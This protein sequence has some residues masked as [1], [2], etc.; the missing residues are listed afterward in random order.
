MRESGIDP[1]P[2]IAEYTLVYD[3]KKEQLKHHKH[4]H[5]KAKAS[6]GPCLCY[7]CQFGRQDPFQWSGSSGSAPGLRFRVSVSVRFSVFWFGFRVSGF[8]FRV[9]DFLVSIFVLCF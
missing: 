1:E 3:D 7:M 6:I 5:P 9:L 4:F 8:G 2:C